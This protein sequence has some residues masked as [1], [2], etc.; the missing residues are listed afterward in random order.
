MEDLRRRLGKARKA[1]AL[2]LTSM[3][4]VPQGEPAGGFTLWCRLPDGLDSAVLARNCLA[5]DVVLAPG[6]VFS[7]SQSAAS[8]L[9]IN[10]AQTS[11]HALDQLRLAM[12]A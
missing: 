11:D 12:R 10:V 4:I 9:R 3:G 2:R 1:M 8:F 5:H 7:P 6:N